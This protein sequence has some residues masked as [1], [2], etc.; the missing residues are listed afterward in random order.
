[1]TYQLQKCL[2]LK[3]INGLTCSNKN[4]LNPSLDEFCHCGAARL[5][6]SYFYSKRHGTTGKKQSKTLLNED[7]LSLSKPS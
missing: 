5:G 6:T 2:V 4:E 3:V 1:M 7:V